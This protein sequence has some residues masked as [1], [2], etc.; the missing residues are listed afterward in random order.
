MNTTASKMQLDWAETVSQVK[1]RRRDLDEILQKLKD[2]S[3]SHGRRN[4]TREVSL[5]ITKVQEA[6][7]WLG[8]ELKRLNYTNPLPCTP[9]VTLEDLAEQ[10]YSR[11]RAHTGGVSI[12]TGRVIPE[13]GELGKEYKEAWIAAVNKPTGNPYPES[14]NPDNTRIEPTADGLKL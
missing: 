2:M 4:P 10:A 1:T 9:P 3:V 8:M 6:I 13:W 11:Y 5:S 14:Y 12:A 7:M